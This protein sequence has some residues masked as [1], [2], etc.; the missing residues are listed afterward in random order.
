[1]SI[2]RL[3]AIALASLFIATSAQAADEFG[4]RVYTKAGK[5]EDV[6]DDV[7]DAIINRGFVIDYVGYFNTMLERTAEA[8]S[9][10]TPLG[11]KSPYKNAEYMQFCPA[12]LTHEAVS[13][14]PFA[15]ANCPIAIFVYEVA[16]DPGKINVGYR[17]PVATPSRVMRQVNDKLMAL[18]DEIASEATKK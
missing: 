18:L 8:T 13:A 15:I 2:L 16:A 5:F 9:S 4:Y 17:L 3:A 12:K 1:M 7:K 14:T 10:V 11:A 6:R